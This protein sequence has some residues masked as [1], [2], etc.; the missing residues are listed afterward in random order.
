M[1][2]YFKHMQTLFGTFETAL[3]SGSNPELPLT[4]D[5]GGTSSTAGAQESLQKSVRLVRA[6]HINHVLEDTYQSFP[7]RQS[8]NSE[9]VACSNRCPSAQGRIP[10]RVQIVAFYRNNVCCVFVRGST[11][12]VGPVLWQGELSGLPCLETPYHYYSFTFIFIYLG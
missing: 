9:R 3:K 11:G 12:G 6:V 1:T 4:S 10:K 2:L 7:F 5:V 8:C